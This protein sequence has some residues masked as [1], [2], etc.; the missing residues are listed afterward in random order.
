[1][2]E[3]VVDHWIAITFAKVSTLF[4]DSSY[5]SFADAA[6]PLNLHFIRSCDGLQILLIFLSHQFSLQFHRPSSPLA[7]HFADI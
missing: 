3:V 4:S 1:V 6:V 7:L 5:L 2:G